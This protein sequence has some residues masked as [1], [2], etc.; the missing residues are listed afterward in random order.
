MKPFKILVV[1][2]LA[3]RGLDI[4][5]SSPRIALDVK[6]GLPPAE[7][8]AAIGGYQGLVVRS[9]TKVTAQLLEAASAM[10]IVGRAGIGVDNIDVRAASRRGI[11]VENTP[12]GNATTAAEHALCLLLSMARYIP[13]A[14]AS[15][16][17]GKW[18]KKKFQGVE[19]TDKT[20]GVV[21]L[22]NIGRIVCDRARGL[23][24]NVVA[25][26]PFIG[27]EAAER[28]GAELV[29]LDELFERADFITIHTPLTPE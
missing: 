4:L 25:Y 17:A 24:M 9:A 21:G 8:A 23:K 7:L 18:E 13:Q 19:I 22:G 26:D 6:V 1:D 2:D 28:L 5:R 27:A 11:I 15:M 12:S 10:K 16:K 29:K 20:L 14:T 3:R